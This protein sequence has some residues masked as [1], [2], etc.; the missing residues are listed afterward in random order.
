M[1]L[2]IIVATG[3]NNAIG[4]DN[5]LLWHLPA[6]L[7]FFK[8]TTL[9][10]TL[11]M[12]RATFDSIGRPLPGRRSIVVTRNPDW[13]ADGVE[14]VHSLEQA[15]ELCKGEEEVFI[16]GGADIYSQ[17]MDKVNRIYRTV[18]ELEP[19]ADRFFPIIPEPDFFKISSEKRPPDEKNPV[20]MHFEV[21]ET[22]K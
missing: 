11:I 1:M 9:G 10:K 15:I 5:Q 14:I 19:E 8:K 21:W 4:K 6:D 16:A 20:T 18:I 3:L 12:G 13:K 7:Q 17:S 2:S 22:R